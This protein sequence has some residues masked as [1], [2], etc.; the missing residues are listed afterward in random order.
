MLIHLY[1]GSCLELNLNYHGCCV[2]SLSPSC[3]NKGCFCD[4]I[5]HIYKDCCSDVADIG[6]HPAPSSTKTIPTDIFGKKN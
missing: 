3:N 6:C 1:I 5:C 4:Q 2:S